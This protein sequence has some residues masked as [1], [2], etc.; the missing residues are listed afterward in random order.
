MERVHGIERPRGVPPVCSGRWKCP[1]DDDLGGRERRVTL[2]ESGR[3]S[4]SRRVEVDVLGIDAVVDDPDLDPTSAVAE[5]P[6]GVWE[7]GA[8][9]ARTGWKGTVAD[10]RIDADHA[11]DRR[12]LVDPIGGHEDCEP[13]EHV[14]VPPADP[15]AR[16]SSGELGLEPSLT[17]A[18][19]VQRS[20]S[21]SL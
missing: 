15:G 1:C 19:P 6:N 4:E 13:V 18:D 17:E 14:C 2:R 12:E 7:Q 11:V 3:C 10:T 16:K 5:R 20:N 9:S 8:C 21:V